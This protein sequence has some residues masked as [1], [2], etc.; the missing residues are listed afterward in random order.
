MW[1][2]GFGVAMLATPHL[3]HAFAPP[4]ATAISRQLPDVLPDAAL[5]ATSWNLVTESE[6]ERILANPGDDPEAFDAAHRFTPGAPLD[7]DPAT[8]GRVYGFAPQQLAAASR[9]LESAFRARRAEEIIA[10]LAELSIAVS[11]LADPYLSG[12]ADGEEVPGA[13]AMFGDDL[14]G[15]SLDALE[16]S[17][18][19]EVLDPAAAGAELGRSSDAQR[20]AIE[21]AFRS[22]DLERVATLRRERLGAALGLARAIV[23]SAWHVT[24]APTLDHA[25]PATGQLTT[26]PSPA[27]G[28]VTLGFS[29]PVTGQTEIELYDIAGRR[30]WNRTIETRS[31]GPQRATIDSHT[32]RSLPAGVYL[33]RVRAANHIAQG[34]LIR[35]QE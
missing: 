8:E 25:A 27:R 35:T 32:I 17:A 34:R 3:S 24:G 12:L 33:A 28:T 15:V 6:I 21:E 5:W 30:L 10:A 19:P 22:G 7:L 18:W 4:A 23:L 14:D 9:H 2:C 13:H 16:P 1:M 29:L 26:W 11:D 20:H 31:P